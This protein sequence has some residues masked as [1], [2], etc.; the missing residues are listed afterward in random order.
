MIVVMSDDAVRFRIQVKECREQAVKAISPL[1]EEAWLRT[2][3]KWLKL[4]VS[5]EG[6]YR[7]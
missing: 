2:A 5:T 4:E 6:R 1:D 7:E 3:E